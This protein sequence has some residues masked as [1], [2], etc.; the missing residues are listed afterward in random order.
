MPTDRRAFL[1][2]ASLAAST[3]AFPA[4]VRSASPNSKLQVV[5]VGANG[6]AF[7]DIKNIGGH[8]KVQYVGFC[9]ID[10]T[11]F[12]KVDADF[13][14]VAQGGDRSHAHGQARLLPETARPYCLG[15]PPDAP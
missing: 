10:S 11:R 6:M 15:G 5:S 9:D 14:G 2:S 3:V 12:D 8:E 7:S 13:P 1:K 4:V